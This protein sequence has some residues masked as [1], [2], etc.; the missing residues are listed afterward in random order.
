MILRLSSIVH[1]CSY[2][3]GVEESNVEP[4]S[5]MHAGTLGSFESILEIEI[6]VYDPI[7]RPERCLLSCY[8]CA[9]CDLKHCRVTLVAIKF[10]MFNPMLDR[11]FIHC[12]LLR[13]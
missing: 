3:V 6:L 2:D 8:G 9:H 7:E 12:F 10:S 13:Q 1:T 5:L 4:V 11:T